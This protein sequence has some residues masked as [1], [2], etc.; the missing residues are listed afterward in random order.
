MKIGLSLKNPPLVVSMP[1]ADAH[2]VLKPN[3]P[4]GN[5]AWQSEGCLTLSTFLSRITPP[6]SELEQGWHFRC[7]CLKYSSGGFPWE[8]M[9]IFC[10][11]DTAVDPGWGLGCVTGSWSCME[12][13]P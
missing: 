3:P 8:N 1:R 11:F 9:K 2:P 12:L 7:V 5:K 4:R 13:L 10:R 6:V